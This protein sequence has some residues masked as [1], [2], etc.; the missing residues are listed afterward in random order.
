VVF[1]DAEVTTGASSDLQQV[2]AGS[3]CWWRCCWCCWLLV[4]LLAL[5]GM[6]HKRQPG[7]G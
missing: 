6:Q 3:C 2:R 7:A 5:G 4:V 1:G